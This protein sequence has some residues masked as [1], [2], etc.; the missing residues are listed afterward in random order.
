MEFDRFTQQSLRRVN[1]WPSRDT[2]RQVGD[3]GRVVRLRLLK[4]GLGMAMLA[5]RGLAPKSLTTVFQ[6][7]VAYFVRVSA[8]NVTPLIALQ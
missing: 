1:S 5:V 8:G 4:I 7:C 6:R 3:V 2:A